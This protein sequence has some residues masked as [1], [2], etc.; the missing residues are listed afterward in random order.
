[1]SKERL[2]VLGPVCAG[3]GIISFAGYLIQGFSAAVDAMTT[4]W[5]LLLLGF[6]IAALIGLLKRKNWARRLQIGFSTI[7]V[8][9][10]ALYLVIV[11]RLEAAL[12]VYIAIP[13]LLMLLNMGC[14][15]ALILCKRQFVSLNLNNLQLKAQHRRYA[16]LVIPVILCTSS[17]VF[18]G[19]AQV[20]TMDRATS[21]EGTILRGT[22]VQNSFLL[23]NNSDAPVKIQTK[24]SCGCTILKA[25]KEMLPHESSSLQYYIHTFNDRPG[26]MDKIVVLDWSQGDQKGTIRLMI[27]YQ[28]TD[29]FLLHEN[30][31]YITRKQNS[32]VIVWGWKIKNPPD[33]KALAPNGIFDFTLEKLS[34][35]RGP[36]LRLIAK[37]YKNLSGLGGT[38]EYAQMVAADGRVIEIPFSVSS[39]FGSAQSSASSDKARDGGGK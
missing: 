22:A 5:R 7:M 18:A 38:V 39:E 36:L 13:V 9:N 32:A 8:L 14:V 31:R 35:N 26:S 19:S 24:A 34:S 30:Q 25:P 21:D 27:T 15:I 11:E 23:T 6:A 29:P 12:Q 1:M 33:I 17:T 37:P 16:A 10:S 2:L 28:I 20:L 4:L 3:I